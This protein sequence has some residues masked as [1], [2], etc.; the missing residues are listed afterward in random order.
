[1]SFETAKEVI[2]WIFKNVPHNMTAVEIQFIGGEPLLEF[3]LIKKI[4]EYTHSKDVKYK[5][6]FLRQQMGHC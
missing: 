6:I 4:I 2:N 5:Y 3:E 1:M